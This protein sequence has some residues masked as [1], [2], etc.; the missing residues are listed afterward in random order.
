[1]SNNE[2]P[3]AERCAEAMWAGD[4]C[5]QHMGMQIERVGEGEAV[6]SMRV[7]ETMVN[8]HNTCHGGMIFALADSAFAFGCNSYNRVT[9]AAGCNIEFLRP[10]FLNDVLTAHCV[11]RTRGKRSGIYDVSVT[12]QDGK[13]VAEFRGKSAQ[14]NGQLVEETES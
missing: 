5:S 2:T 14:I 13:R 9:V 10:A 4:R 7:N 1:M 12:N 11:E 8:G 3:L 6:L